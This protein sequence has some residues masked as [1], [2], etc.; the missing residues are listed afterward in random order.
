MAGCCRV[1]YTQNHA[2]LA[3]T[4]E[5]CLLVDCCC[6]GA[7][8]QG[9][10]LGGLFGGSADN[11]VLGD[12]QRERQVQSCDVPFSIVRSNFIRQSPGGQA[13][14]SL[15]QAEGNGAIKGACGLH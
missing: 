12:V 10:L 9:G 4:L 5:G 13:N 11:G 7:S 3:L 15:I 2:N 1:V 6:A 14:I 8:G